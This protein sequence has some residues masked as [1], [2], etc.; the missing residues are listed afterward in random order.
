MVATLRAAQ[1]AADV[2]GV[3]IAGLQQSFQVMEASI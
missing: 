1:E 2:M 3:Q